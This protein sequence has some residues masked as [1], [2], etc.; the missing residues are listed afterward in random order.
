MLPS[1]QA[2]RP[3]TLAVDAR[4][5]TITEIRLLYSS[6]SFALTLILMTNL[7]KQVRP[8]HSSG[9]TAATRPWTI[10]TPPWLRIKDSKYSNGLH[11][12]DCD[13]PKGFR[14]WTSSM[15]DDHEC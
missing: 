14:D 12:R 6:F 7:G 15:I 13:V 1:T 5:G 3:S 10:F 9:K 11:Q 8:R 2:F 4:T